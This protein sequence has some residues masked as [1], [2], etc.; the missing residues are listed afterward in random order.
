MSESRSIK[1]SVEAGRLPST[2]A[3]LTEEFR[4]LGVP[5]GGVLMVHAAMS[6][7][8]YVVGGAQAVVEALLA[9]LGPEGTLVMPA[10]SGDRGDPAP[11]QH[12]PVPEAWWQIFRDEMP[13]FDPRG[14][15]TRC[16]GAVAETFRTWEGALRSAHPA[17]SIAARGPLA[18]A[19]VGHHPLE[20]GMG[21]TS[22]LAR[23]YDHDAHVLLLGV[24]HG[25]NSSLHL[26][27]HRGEGIRLEAVTEGAPVLVDGERRWV[28]YQDVH[29]FGEDFDAL[30]E[31]F[32]QET[33][34]E[35][36]GPVGLGTARLCRQRAVVDYG[37][38]WLEAHRRP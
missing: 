14:T 19:I 6:K 1:A 8:G 21:E 4:A 25:N 33:E 10:F 9:A 7:L 31:A 20:N 18:E 13:A 16:M 29:T 30:G 38:T 36:T 28:L 15:P 3:S 35:R 26:S 17:N 24:D 27:E 23:L 32:A 37:V 12:P 11:W 2:V 22:P 5:S 34:A